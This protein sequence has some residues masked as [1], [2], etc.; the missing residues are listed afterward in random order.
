[1]W[2]E[3]Y[4]NDPDILSD[5]TE[6]AVKKLGYWIERRLREGRSLFAAR[7]RYPGI[8][9][10]CWCTPIG[11]LRER[12]SGNGKT[13]PPGVMVISNFN[14]V[15]GGRN[16]ENGGGEIAGRTE[17]RGETRRLKTVERGR[18]DATSRLDAVINDIPGE[19]VSCFMRD[20]SSPRPVSCLLFAHHEIIQPVV[21]RGSDR[22]ILFA[23]SLAPNRSPRAARCEFIRIP[24]QHAKR[25]FVPAAFYKRIERRPRL[26]APLGRGATRRLSLHRCKTVPRA[27]LP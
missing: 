10:L 22:S 6:I 24:R 12:R 17:R 26:R 9:L 27:G 14:R 11:Q 18:L 13:L 2:S 1:M 5:V 4:I 15:L 23:D 21:P 7:T 16:R 3:L 19:S 25:L 8:P 20:S